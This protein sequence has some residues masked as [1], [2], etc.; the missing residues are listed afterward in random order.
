[1]REPIRPQAHLGA[2][3]ATAKPS[4]DGAPVGRL[5]SPEGVELSFSLAGPASRMFAYS[6]D[7]A[8]ILA[9]GV[10]IFIAVVSAALSFD[11]LAGYFSS[12]ME[13]MAGVNLQDPEELALTFLPIV[14]VVTVLFYFGEVI[15]FVICETLMRGRSPG[16]LMVGLRVVQRGGRPL[17]LRASLLRNL[18][19]I[20]DVLPA[21]Y[22]V[23]LVAMVA[24]NDYQRLGDRV[25]DTLVIRLDRHA[26]AAPLR[27]TRDVERIPLTRDK[28]ARLGASEL[29]LIRGTLRRAESASLSR[30]HALLGQAAAALARRLEL[31]PGEAQHDPRLFLERLLVT[32]EGAS[33]R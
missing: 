17:D 19:R 24:S 3:A 5:T 15:Y 8:V 21:Q 10:A 4:S 12:W 1:M 23:G 14:I 32:I 18:L 16:K 29:A 9:V 7:F 13:R 22:L 26:P 30:Q 28:L 11:V 31:D 2:G 33:N 6:L 25:A 20:V 27:A